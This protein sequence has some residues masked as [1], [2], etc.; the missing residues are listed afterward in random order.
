MASAAHFGQLSVFGLRV[1]CQQRA[2]QFSGGQATK[3]WEN[4]LQDLFESYVSDLYKLRESFHVDL[5]STAR[6][7]SQAM[8]DYSRC[9]EAR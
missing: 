1:R 6:E 9:S 8:D 5:T 2:N 3:E 4:P 7:L